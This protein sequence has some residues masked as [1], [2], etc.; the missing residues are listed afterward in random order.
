MASLL[1]LAAGWT[2]ATDG[3]PTMPVPPGAR[4]FS[5][6]PTMAINGIPSRIV[7][8]LS[9]ESPDALRKWYRSA[10]GAPL[11]ESAVRHTI[12]LGRAQGRYYLT[13]Q[14]APVPTGTRGVV[15]VANMGEAQADQDRAR[16]AAQHWLDR[17]PAETRI[18]SQVESSDGH[19]SSLYLVMM[20]RNG[21]RTNVD[22]LKRTLRED[23]YRAEQ[24]APTDS[25]DGQP[26]WSPRSATLY[27]KGHDREVIA[28][29]MPMSGGRTAVVINRL[30]QLAGY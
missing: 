7:G 28:I 10:L 5:V 30:R 26:E 9:N 23:G 2:W 17:L 13:I 25:R 1:L 15:S 8:F 14:L 24:D 4:P 12:V 16:E 21:L 6:G 11:V 29:V 18:L 22:H 3:W 19:Q 20:N 27:F